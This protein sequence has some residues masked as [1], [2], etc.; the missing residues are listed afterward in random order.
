MFFLKF[1]HEIKK[2]VFVEVTHAQSKIS[3]NIEQ[4]LV[5]SNNLLHGPPHLSP[6]PTPQK[7]LLFTR[8]Y[9]YQILNFIW[10]E[11]NYQYN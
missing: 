11:S 3:G 1:I 2:K 5:K 8:F 6:C 9:Y 10:P 7:H 4:L